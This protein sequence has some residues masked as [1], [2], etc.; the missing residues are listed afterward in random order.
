M[1]KRQAGII[2]SGETMKV[3]GFT[4]SRRPGVHAHVQALAKRLRRKYWILYHLKKTG[5]T[6]DE[7]AKVYR[8]CI[9]PVA[10]YCSVVY[11]SLL[12]DEQDQV[13]ERIQAGALRAIY[14]YE[15]P[16]G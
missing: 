8:T 4:L 3:L 15:I 6:Q 10:D 16:Y 5:F 14:G 12:T 2:E 1:Y 13:L 7:L 11:H 9:L